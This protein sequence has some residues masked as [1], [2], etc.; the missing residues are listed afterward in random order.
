MAGANVLASIDTQHSD[1]IVSLSVAYFS[2]PVVADC[3][4]G[5]T[6]L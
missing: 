1:M 4:R 5:T 3:I 2:W 6:L